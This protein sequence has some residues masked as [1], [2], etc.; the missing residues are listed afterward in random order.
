[1]WRKLALTASLQALRSGPGS[2]WSSASLAQALHA[3]AAIGSKGDLP[4]GMAALPAAS[5]Q[6]QALMLHEFQANSA[7]GS[8]LAL[9]NSTVGA[10]VLAFPFAFRQTG[11]AAGLACTFLVA[12]VEAF[13]MYVLARFAEA[14]GSQTYSVLVRFSGTL[15]VHVAVG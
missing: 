15:R 13:S 9:I 5:A 11:W 4:N 2:E 14:T 12:V 6:P 10:G 1:L 8:V 7:R 3:I